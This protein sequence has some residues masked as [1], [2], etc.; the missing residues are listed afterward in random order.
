ML[1]CVVKGLRRCWQTSDGPLGEGGLLSGHAGAGDGVG[2]AGRQIVRRT[3]G[4][5]RQLSGQA[6][7]SDVG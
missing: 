4:G 5:V 2:V 6:R 1:L 7:H 3:A